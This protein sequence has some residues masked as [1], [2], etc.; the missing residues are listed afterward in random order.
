MNHQKCPLYKNLPIS[1][2]L[3]LFLHNIS[4]KMKILKVIAG[5]WDKNLLQKW[6]FKPPTLNFS[7]VIGAYHTAFSTW[8]TGVRWKL[9]EFA[10]RWCCAG[11]PEAFE[12]LEGCGRCWF[13]WFGWFAWFLLVFVGWLVCLVWFGLVWLVKFT[14]LAGL[15]LEGCLLLGMFRWILQRMGCCFEEILG[16]FHSIAS[17]WEATLHMKNNLKKRSYTADFLAKS[18]WLS[19]SK[20]QLICRKK[21]EIMR[22]RCSNLV[23]YHTP[24][25]ASS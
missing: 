4:P 5:F 10:G 22:V 12:I 23:S 16:G 13:G 24:F 9:R 8:I 21:L 2:K 14:F 3:L 20:Y 11:I 19:L 1:T 15:T 17:S 7:S 18:W 6:I 25:V